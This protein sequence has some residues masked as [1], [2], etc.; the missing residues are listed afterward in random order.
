[1]VMPLET[2]YK[3]TD[4]VRTTQANDSQRRPQENRS[5]ATRTLGE[6]RS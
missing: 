4:G 5:S 2:L 3:V 6:D 1:M